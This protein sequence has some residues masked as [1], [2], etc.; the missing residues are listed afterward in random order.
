MSQATSQ[1]LYTPSLGGSLGEALFRFNN[2]Y[3]SAWWWWILKF[4]FLLLNKFLNTGS[5][6]TPLAPITMHEMKIETSRI[7]DATLQPYHTGEPLT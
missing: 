4:V 5:S 1:N 3:F 6:L 2:S 7:L